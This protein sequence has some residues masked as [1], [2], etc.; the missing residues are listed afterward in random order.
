MH[1][2]SPPARGLQWRSPLQTSIV[3]LEE[4]FGP[5]KEVIVARAPGR[6]NL[7]GEHTD[8]NGGYV[9]PFA[10]DR[11]TSIAVRAREDMRVRIYASAFDEAFEATLPLD[12]PSPTGTWRDYPIGILL[13][14]RKHANLP[15]GF[16]AVIS[17]N[18]PLGAG[19]SSSASL[20]VALA[21]SLSHLYDIELEDLEL[22]KLCQHA[23]NEFVGTQSGIM[24]QYASL[25]ARD[26]SAILLN[27]TSLEHRSIPLELGGTTLLVVNSGVQRELAS[28]GYNERRRECQEAL[29]LLRE[30]LPERELRSLSDLSLDDLHQLE[31]TIPE[32]LIMRARHVV[33]ENARVLEMVSALEDGDMRSAGRLLFSSHASLRDLFQVS[34]KELDFLV[35]WGREHGALGARLVGGGFGGATLHLIPRDHAAEY[36]EK[37]EAAYHKRFGLNATTIE[38]RPSP[39]AKESATKKT[40]Y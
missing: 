18:V 21:L 34:T 28:S 23:E 5:G 9:L 31:H 11:F 24:D 25:L 33:E 8:Y 20:E 17:G 39:G 3:L 12:S 15:F 19:L 26:R 10:I 30:A 6:V 22:V 32:A 37:I 16:D 38:V 36:A 40:L 14:L 2:A 4:R 35:D 27:T 7:I 1:F 29:R 13:E